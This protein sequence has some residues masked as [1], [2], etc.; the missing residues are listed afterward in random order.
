M[1][2]TVTLFILVWEHAH[3]L[4]MDGNPGLSAYLSIYLCLKLLKLKLKW[5]KK[6]KKKKSYNSEL[7]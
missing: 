4:Q 1:D 6:A 3:T 7:Q 2:C 5:K